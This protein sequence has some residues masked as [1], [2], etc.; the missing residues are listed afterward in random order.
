VVEFLFAAG[1][2]DIILKISANINLLWL[3]IRYYYS[4]NRITK[5]RI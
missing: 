5:W 4:Q 3:E 2:V 1:E